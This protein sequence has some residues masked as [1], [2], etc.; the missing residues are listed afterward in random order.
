MKD[1]FP[2][3]FKTKIDSVKSKVQKEYYYRSGNNDER[4]V[5]NIA[6][7]DKTALVNKINSIF[8]RPDFVYQADVTIMYKT[9][10]SINEKVVGI[11]DN[12]LLTINGEKIYIDEIYDIK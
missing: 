1:K 11:K 8:T 3:I 7:P 6:E 12:Y 5:S 10:K 9:G 4:S 2:E